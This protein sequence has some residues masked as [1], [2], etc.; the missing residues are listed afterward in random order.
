MH[1]IIKNMIFLKNYLIAIIYSMCITHQ[2][3]NSTSTNSEFNGTAVEQ[4]FQRM[5]EGNGFNLITRT[6]D[7]GQ[8]W[9]KILET[10]TQCLFEMNFKNNIKIYLGFSK[11]RD[12]PDMFNVFDNNYIQ[13][14][15]TT[16]FIK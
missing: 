3:N 9:Y 8:F 4:I 16:L 11:T 13:M 2:I 5:F 1:C 12:I 6:Y 7:N 14:N 15:I 10:T